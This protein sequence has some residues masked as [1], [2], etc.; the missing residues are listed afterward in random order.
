MGPNNQRQA[1]RVDTTDSLEHYPLGITLTHTNITAVPEQ[2]TGKPRTSHT[3]IFTNPF[4]H[5]ISSEEKSTGKETH[6]RVEGLKVCEVTAL[7]ISPS[8]N[9]T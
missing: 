2:H 9:R 5:V 8:F 6:T 7:F 4:F 1:R 3:G